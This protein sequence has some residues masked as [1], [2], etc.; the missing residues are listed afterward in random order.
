MVVRNII[1]HDSARPCSTYP[2]TNAAWPCSKR[3]GSAITPSPSYKG[4]APGRGR[5]GHL[6]CEAGQTQG[7]PADSSPGTSTSSD[8]T[9]PTA[10]HCSYREESDAGT[11]SL[12]RSDAPRE[13][14]G[15]GFRSAGSLLA[16]SATTSVTLREGATETTRRGE[17]A[18]GIS[19]MCVQDHLLTTNLIATVI[20]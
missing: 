5:H 1:P 2:C 4:D 6:T 13:R 19:S 9:T 15:R 14:G 18:A 11:A 17:S 10:C 20:N 3:K 7:R 16:T 8:G 12:V